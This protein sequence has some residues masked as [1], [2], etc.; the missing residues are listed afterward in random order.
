MI[1]C[2][3]KLNSKKNNIRTGIVKTKNGAIKTPFFMPDATKGFIRSLDKIDLESLKMG[4][5]VVNTYHLYLKPGMEVIKKAGGIHKFMNFSGPLLSD[6][7][8]YQIFSLIHK[9]PKMGKITDH[10]VIFKSPYDGSTHKL[11]PEK[12]IEIQFDLGVDMMVVL[13]DPPP[14]SYSKEKIKKAVE[15]TIQWAKRCQEEYKKQIKKRKIKEKEKPLIFCVIQGGEHLDLRKHC[16]EELIKIGGWDGYGFGGRHLNS[17]GQFMEEVLRQ[18]AGFIPENSLRFALGIGTPKDIIKCYALGWDMFDCVIPTR[19]GRHGRLFLRTDLTSTLS[20]L[21][22]GSKGEVNF[23]ETININ[24]KKFKTD[25]SPVDK[26]CDCRLCRNYTRAYL[27][28]LFVAG[29]PLALRLAEIHNL[30]FYLD[31]MKKLRNSAKDATV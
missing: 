26:N 15:R 5:M 10:E 1:S 25:F 14:N 8:G 28:H 24:N 16:A 11:T 23:Y 2:V 7:G 4:P 20:L 29:D 31:L 13:D 6:S 12:S 19:E 18:T 27:R 9:N 30:K 3:F 22:R 21:R 17:E